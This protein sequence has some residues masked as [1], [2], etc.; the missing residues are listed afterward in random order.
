[1]MCAYRKGRYA[2]RHELQTRD[3]VQRPVPRPESKGTEIVN[4][5]NIVTRVPFPLAKGAAY[6]V[7]RFLFYRKSVCG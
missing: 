7:E 3:P 6:Y 4:A 1:M 2:S 5:V